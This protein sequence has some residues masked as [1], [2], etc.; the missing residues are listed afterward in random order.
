M[1]IINQCFL[2][3]KNS[4]LNADLRGGM[5][6]IKKGDEP[7]IRGTKAVMQSAITSCI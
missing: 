6:V 7:I 4:E 3:S 1:K 5:G 2:L